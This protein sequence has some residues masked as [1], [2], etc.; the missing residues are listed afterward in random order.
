MPKLFLLFSITFFVH[1]AM[2]QP[3]IP[4]FENLSVNDGLPH[5]SVYSITQDKKGFMWFGTADGLCRYDG[6]ILKTFKYAATYENDVINNFIRGKILE[7]KTG[8]IWYCNETGIYKWDKINE[9]VVRIKAFG[10]S[11]FDNTGFQAVYMDTDNCIWLFNLV[12]GIFKFNI[13]TRQM[14]RFPLPVKFDHNDIVHRFINTDDRGNIWLRVG[15]KNTPL[16]IFNRQTLQYSIQFAD[17]PPQSIYFDKQK[18]VLVYYD[19]LVFPEKKVFK[20]LY[21]KKAGF[22]SYDGVIDNNGR[23]WMAAIGN[24]LFSYD[25]KKNI[26][27]QF[28]HDN[29]K[30]K[31]LP[32]DLASCLFIDRNENLWIG[33]DGAG[34][35]KL[36]L[37]EPRFNLFPLSEGDFPVSNDYFTKCFYEDEVGRI[38][39]GTHSNGLNILDPKKQELVNYRHKSGDRNALPGDIVGS[40][41]KDR[42]GILWIGSNGGISIFDESKKTFTTIPI[43]N[44]PPSNPAMNNFVYKMVQLQNENILVATSLGI[45]KITQNEKRKFEGSFFSDTRHLSS[46]TIDIAEMP[47]QV[48]Y[49][50]FPNLG[51]YKFKP[52]EDSYS[53]LNIFLPGIDLRSIRIDEQDGHYLWIGSAK[54]LIHFNTRNNTYTTWDEKDGLANNYVYGSLED[55]SGHLWISTN[56]GLSVLNRT[57]NTFENFSFQ[58]GLQSNEF[59]TQAFY[60][61]NS[62]TFYFGGI[63]GFNWFK[64]GAI[65]KENKKPEAAITDVAINDSI[66]IRDSSFLFDHTIRVPYDKNDFIFRF[67]ALDYTRPEANKVHY[68]LEGWDANWVASDNRTARYS[69]LPPGKYS[70]RLK[71]SNSAGVWSEEEKIHILIQPPFWKRSWFL[72]TLSLVLIGVVAFITY[73]IAQTKSERKLRLLEQKIALDAERNRIS[74]DMH[75]EIGSGI[76]HIALLSELIQKQHKEEIDF[77]K[78]INIIATSARKLVQTMSEIIWALNPQNET[79]ENLLAYTREQSQQLFES[80]NIQLHIDFPELIPD[81]KLTNVQRRN[82]YLVTREALNNALKHSDASNILL[83]FEVVN[84]HYCFSVMDDGKGLCKQNSKFGRNGFTNMQNRM[85]DIDGTIEW[86]S[87]E[88]GVLVTYCFTAT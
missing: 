37:K 49:A 54:G 83:K 74:A 85:K 36:D 43:H 58:D 88:K 52:E 21:N 28:H 71:V 6:N 31:S 55:K 56:K 73:E 72:I 9:R 23:L 67:A 8:S 35:A 33:L 79:L 48:V 51:L 76:T 78:D 70:L 84:N 39:F 16:L 25:N 61:G 62:G 1:F 38:W 59:N 32:F 27:H 5:S 66:F 50:A 53:L 42:R 65:P 34:V 82:L 24:G 45:I 40:I 2:A 57:N 7:D 63:K 17:D 4:R 68:F 12:F 18:K 11:E 60:K 26:L 41:L 47:D 10:K 14:L 22:Y 13:L 69:N 77:K 44:F 15:N 46:V 87:L 81:I 75:D 30:V 86:Q 80:M 3:I 64:P 19:R 29:S 20:I